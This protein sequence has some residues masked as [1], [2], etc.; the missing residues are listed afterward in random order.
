MGIKDS[1]GLNGIFLC[2]QARTQLNIT[3]DKEQF[4]I[5]KNEVNTDENKDQL[6][7]CFLFGTYHKAKDGLFLSKEWVAKSLEKNLESSQK[8][9]DNFKDGILTCPNCAQKLNFSK[10]AL[11]LKN[12]SKML[13]A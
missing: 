8:I 10:E 1:L 9:Q 12:R 11:F 5:L 4:E 6:K 2:D 3:L 7:K 13:T